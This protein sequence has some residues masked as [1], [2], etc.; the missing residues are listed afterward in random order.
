VADR[1][2]LKYRHTTENFFVYLPVFN[3]SF[4]RC[5]RL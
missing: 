2:A 3:N 5:N 4:V 1:N